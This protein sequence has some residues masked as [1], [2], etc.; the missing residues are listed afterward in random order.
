MSCK[1]ELIAFVILQLLM[2]GPL[3]AEDEDIVDFSE[4]I[5]PVCE[6]VGLRAVPPN[7][8]FNVPIDSEDDAVSGCQMMRAGEEQELVGILRLLS[9]RLPEDEDAPPW[10]AVLIA[11]EQQV[12]SEMGYT[13]GEVL[14]AR[15]EV[16]ISGDG[17][18]NA[19]A[20]GLAATIEGND[21]PQEAHFL[22]FDRAADK[23]IITLLT[24]AKTVDEG[25]YYKR[26]TDD[27]GILIRSLNQ[28]S[29]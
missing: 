26:N 12:I 20:V 7:G 19:R 6:I 24:P 2:I 1:K 4:H 18:G 16:P 15:P 11:M 21:A 29:D 28:K 25:V 9:A 14:W 27:F 17:F 3:I 10:F 5:T 23:F 22:V 8:W 13:L